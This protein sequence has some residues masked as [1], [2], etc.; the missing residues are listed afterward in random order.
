MELRFIH[1]VRDHQAK[2]NFSAEKGDLGFMSQ[3]SGI[4]LVDRTYSYRGLSFQSALKQD[5]FVYVLP[6]VISRE[7]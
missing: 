1:V 3:K 4:L 6:C 2:Y 5:K 7:G